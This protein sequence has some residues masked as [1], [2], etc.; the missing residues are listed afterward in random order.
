MSFIMKH[1]FLS[2]LSL[3]TLCISLSSCAAKEYKLSVTPKAPVANF[4]SRSIE[5]TGG[6][7]SVSISTSAQ[8]DQRFPKFKAMLE[9][10]LLNN[11]IQVYAQSPETDTLALQLKLNQL[12]K[13]DGKK[14]DSENEFSNRYFYVHN[15]SKAFSETSAFEYFGI[16]QKNED[17]FTV[18]IPSDTYFLDASLFDSQK[19]LLAKTIIKIQS[20]A[21]LKNAFITTVKIHNQDDMQPTPHWDDLSKQN[22]DTQSLKCLAA[23]TA[24][25]LKEKRPQI[26]KV[27]D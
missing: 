10:S 4:S 11:D 21:C 2:L 5:Y 26:F 9:A 12:S 7:T 3:S 20:L 23:H 22:L 16:Y 24:L 15:E 19:Q 27:Q 18:A 1:R 8:I 14:S 13:D 17:Y 25:S 6:A